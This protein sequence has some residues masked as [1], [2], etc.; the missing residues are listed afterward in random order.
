L[1]TTRTRDT[2]CCVGT[3]GGHKRVRAQFTDT[4]KL[5]VP[6]GFLVA[7]EAAAR[8]DLC[9]ASEYIRRSVINRLRKDGV[10]IEE[11]ADGR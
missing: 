4:V 10:P 8:Q 2:I 9:T 6:P 7:V 3:F 5:R 1:L 11:I